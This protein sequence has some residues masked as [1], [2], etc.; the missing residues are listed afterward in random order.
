MKHLIAFA[1]VTAAFWSTAPDAQAGVLFSDSFNRVEGSGDPNGKPADPNNF[2]DWGSNDNALGGSNTAAWLV[3]PSRGGGANAVTDGDL[4]SLIEGVGRTTY[5]A[6]AQ[7]PNGF[8]VAFDFGRFAPVSAGGSGG[9]FISV[10]LGFDP[11]VNAFGSAANT[12]D[13]EFALLFQ[14]GVGGNTGNTQFFEDGA[15]LGA[16][17]SEGPVDYG[18]PLAEHSVLLT[19]VPQTPGAYGSADTIDGAVSIDGG[20][21]YSFSVQ[22]GPSFGTVSFSSN[23]FVH[24]YIDNLVITAI[25]EPAAALLSL[26]VAGTLVGQR[27]RSR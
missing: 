5:D 17:G 25:P 23:Q 3:G 21:P 13:S 11:T 7:A 2:A 22:G 27:R 15:F 18:D 4:A 12:S 14:Q 8:S 26:M 10:A 6:L 16:T 1:L 24:R 19:F 9:G 20:S